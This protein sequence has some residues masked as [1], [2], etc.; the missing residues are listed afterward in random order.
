MASYW[1]REFSLGALALACALNAAGMGGGLGIA[2]TALVPAAPYG[3]RQAPRK[4]LLRQQH[5]LGCT[6]GR[7]SGTWGG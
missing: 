1:L 6:H 2:R 4:A 7:R 5:A 3:S